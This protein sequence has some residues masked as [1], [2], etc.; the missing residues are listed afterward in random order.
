VAERHPALWTKTQQRL[1][2][3]VVRLLPPG[4]L[5]SG[6]KIRRLVDERR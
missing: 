4:T 3:I 6:R 5:R 1:C 2:D